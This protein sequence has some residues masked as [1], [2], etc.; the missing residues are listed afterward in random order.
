MLEGKTP[1]VDFFV[2]DTP[3][4]LLL[5]F[6]PVKLASLL[7][8]ESGHAIAQFVIA[9]EWLVSIAS[10]SLTTSLIMR[11][12]HLRESFRL[13]VL[14]LTFA[15]LNLSAL[16]QFGQTTHI[17][18][19]GLIPYTLARWLEYR[20]NRLS[21]AELLACG[22]GGGIAILL[23]PLFIIIIPTLE[24]ILASQFQRLVPKAECTLSVLA[25]TAASTM[26]VLSV[27]GNR[28]MSGYS[29]Y[30]LPMLN[31]DREIFD[32]QLYGFPNSPDSR[33]FVYLLIAA[34][35]LAMGLRKRSSLLTPLTASAWLGFGYYVATGKGF[36]FQALPMFWA[37][38]LVLAIVVT[39][40]FADLR[41]F[42]VRKTKNVVFKRSL[43][44][45]PVAALAFA[46]L[47]VSA[48]QVEN[49]Q[50]V[51]ASTAMV[52][53]SG[54]GY[55]NTGE[56]V[57]KIGHLTERLDKIIVLSESLAPAYPLM[58][59]QDRKPGSRFMS[60]FYIPILARIRTEGKVK[61]AECDRLEKFYFDGLQED[62]SAAKSAVVFV[63]DGIAHDMLKERNLY[64]V[65]Q[66][67]YTVAAEEESTFFSDNV[68]PREFAGMNFILRAYKFSF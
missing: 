34:T 7:G 51:L 60:A 23:D 44:P 39:I 62:L 38:S 10:L 9:F 53:L 29:S 68:P 31:I 41:K 16:Y 25:I 46:M 2:L 18:T 5:S 47:T 67:H 45:A 15:V 19:L 63:Q 43:A 54:N 37:S 27:A 8:F 21:R 22:I 4:A 6:I 12:N 56:A 66:Q 32:R 13:K 64:P 40:L 26:A 11:R 52:R 35:L 59:L 20:G 1:Y 30:I 36:Y 3:P 42:L 65:L 55:P 24:I 28:M 33:V 57:Y 50:Q 17:L 61:E 49:K 58:T 48:I 14:L